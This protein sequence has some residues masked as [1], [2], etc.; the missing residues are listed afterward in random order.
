MTKTERKAIEK[1]ALSGYAAHLY[2]GLTVRGNYSLG[3]A[4]Q[5]WRQAKEDIGSIAP[6]LLGFDTNVFLLIE[7]YKRN[8]A[9]LEAY[10]AEEVAKEIAPETDHKSRVEIEAERFPET[11]ELVAFPSVP[12][13]IVRT[14]SYVN[15]SNQVQLVLERT[16]NRQHF[17]K[18]TPSEIRA[19][20]RTK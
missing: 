12:L 20:I 16:D 10:I 3:E 17:G 19:Q 4:I 2:D 14:F 1:L 8:V 9:R 5:Y 7:D 13:R 11:F 18:G 6:Q 15:D